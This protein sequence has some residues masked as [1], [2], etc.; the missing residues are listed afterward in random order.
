MAMLAVLFDL[1]PQDGVGGCAADGVAV[2][3]QT[4]GG[5]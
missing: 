5:E 4:C 3:L 2:C 1:T